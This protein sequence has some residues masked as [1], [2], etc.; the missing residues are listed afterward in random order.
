MTVQKIKQIHL[1]YLNNIIFNLRR[2]FFFVWILQKVYPKYNFHLNMSDPK[3][4]TIINHSP[5]RKIIP[6]KMVI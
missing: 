2:D 1:R 3:L 5:K 4:D 6:T